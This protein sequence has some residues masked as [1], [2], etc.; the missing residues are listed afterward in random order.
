MD[1]AVFGQ[2]HAR[3][4]TI[5]VVDDEPAIRQIASTTLEAFNYK[6]LSASDG[7]EAIALFA[8][9]RTEIKAVLTD[10][11]MPLMDGVALIRALR[12]LAPD[13][14]IIASS[15]LASNGKTAEVSREGAQA[16]LA[17]PY[18]ASLL[19]QTLARVLAT[20]LTELPERHG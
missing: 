17:K 18:T 1:A 9:H 4:H 14:R 20:P 6:V 10:L 19:L 16:F 12:K 15:G 3:V 13:I 5:L 11:M 7:A 2:S 8:Q